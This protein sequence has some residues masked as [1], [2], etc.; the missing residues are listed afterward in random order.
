MKNLLKKI[1][2]AAKKPTFY[3]YLPAGIYLIL[4]TILLLMPA[5]DLPKNPFLELIFFDKWV[6]TGIFCLLCILWAFPGIS[7][8]KN[9]QMHIFIIAFCCIF[10]AILTEYAQK[11]LTTDRS[12][13]NWDI[14]AD[15]MGVVVASIALVYFKK[16]AQKISN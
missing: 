2:V 14:V 6:H 5:S 8:F 12:Y 3:S 7:Y 4:I 16:K 9:P 11:N 13:D 15:T 1:E 10:Y